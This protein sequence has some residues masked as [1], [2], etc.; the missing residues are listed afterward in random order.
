MRNILLASLMILTN[1]LSADLVKIGVILPLT[2]NNDAYGQQCLSGVRL[3]E[4]ELKERE[5]KGELKNH[6]QIIVED[7]QLVGRLTAEALNKLINLDHVQAL[8]TTTG[9][10]GN[11]ANPRAEKAKIIHIGVTTD[12]RVAQGEYNFT[13]WTPP[14]AEAPLLVEMI[15]RMEFKR[16][17]IINQRQQS[18][19]LLA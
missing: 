17:A 12:T 14:Q 11:V 18:M 16:I 10:S 2:G 15:K 1:I 6:Y 8:I 9:T 7:D 5:A 13:H 4:H 3:F 19:I